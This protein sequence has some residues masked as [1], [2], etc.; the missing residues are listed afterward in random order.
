MFIIIY[1]YVT[2]SYI[3]YMVKESL[4]LLAHFLNHLIESSR[5]EPESPTATDAWHE[6]MGKLPIKFDAHQTSIHLD[7]I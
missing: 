6:F 2:D 3:G 5:Q 7:T 1:V 4:P